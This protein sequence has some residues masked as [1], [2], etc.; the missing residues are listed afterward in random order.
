M[1]KTPE[2]EDFSDVEATKRMEAA[3]RKALATP[4]RPHVKPKKKP[5]KRRPAKPKSA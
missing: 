3:V 1:Q 4:H 5:V 2:N